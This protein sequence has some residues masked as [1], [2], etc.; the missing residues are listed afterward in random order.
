[1]T[2]VMAYERLPMDF[3]FMENPTRSQNGVTF[4]R[5]CKASLSRQ[6]RSVRG[7]DERKNEAEL[8][9]FKAAID[10]ILCARESAC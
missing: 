1:M 9:A 7:G 5:N 8:K 2:P 10:D 6:V 3:V 4:S